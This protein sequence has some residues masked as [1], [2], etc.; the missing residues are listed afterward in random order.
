[1]QGLETGPCLNVF[2]N[3]PNV[4]LVSIPHTTPN[5]VEIQM[6]IS[7]MQITSRILMEH[8]MA[9]RAVKRAGVFREHIDASRAAWR[10]DVAKNKQTTSF[11]IASP[12][13]IAFSFRC[14]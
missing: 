6:S 13:T 7:A 4:Q 3:I 8:V 11:M 1:M 14:L 2:R 9:L 5:S 10:T 12:K